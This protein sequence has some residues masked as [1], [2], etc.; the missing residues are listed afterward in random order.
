M[1]DFGKIWEYL[2]TPVA[3]S[4]PKLPTGADVSP[5]LQQ[6][7]P[8][9]ADYTSDG[10]VYGTPGKRLNKGIKWRDEANAGEL[11]SG[12]SYGGAQVFPDLSK[13]AQ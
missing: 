13:V 4:A 7:V 5:T 12:G 6:R 11:R 3:P 9:K 1:G 10:A 2:G 8:E